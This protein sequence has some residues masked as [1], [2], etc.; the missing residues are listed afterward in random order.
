MGGEE[1]KLTSGTRTKKRKQMLP[2]WS[3]YEPQNADSS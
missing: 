1:R 2:R 3:T